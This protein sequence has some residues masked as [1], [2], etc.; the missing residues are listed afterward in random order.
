MIKVVLKEKYSSNNKDDRFKLLET[1]VTELCQEAIS[2][3][4]VFDKVF[5]RAVAVR[6]ERKAQISKGILKKER[7]GILDIEFKKRKVL[8]ITPNLRGNRKY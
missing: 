8:K 6:I 5:T 2:V 1:G 3:I 4:L 7:S